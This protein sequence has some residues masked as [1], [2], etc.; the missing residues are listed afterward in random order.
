MPM[1]LRLPLLSL[2]LVLSLPA[3]AQPLLPPPGYRQPV[4]VS[5]SKSFRCPTP[6][7]PY[8]KPLDFPSKYEGSGKA[9]DQVNAQA[10][11]KY[12]SLTAP[13]T[14]MEKGV[15]KLVNRYLA[16]G[17]PAVLAC[18]LDWYQRW[19]D[20][21]ALRGTAVNHTGRSV[22]K[23]ALASLSGAWLRLRHAGNA[24]L[25]DETARAQRIERWLGAIGDQVLREWPANA[26]RERIN[27]HYYWAGWALMATSVATQRPDL[28][29]ASLQ[30][31]RVFATQ[32]DEDGYLP[33]ELARETRAL[34]YHNYSLGPLAMMAAFA[35]A[36]QVDLASEG[37]G[38]LQRLAQRTFM[39]LE[40]PSI[41]ERR[42]GFPQE[43]SDFDEPQ[44]K[45]AW[46]E[47]YCWT[48]ECGSEL[49]KR[50]D[51]LR[52]LGSYRLGGNLTPA[53][54]ER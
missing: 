9:R 49:R 42:T 15:S 34:S 29:D 3:T 21:N 30:L 41:F 4:P 6:P 51:A 47:P 52:P 39:G 35:R 2:L 53:F 19:S 27:N 26:A 10:E 37:Q 43:L 22:R 16:S 14:E 44:T 11:A 46:L 54:A 50:R 40:D 13:I 1:S 45:L 33:N 25:A 38:A 18:T 20:A 17:N 31:Y 23:W 36:N 48:L 8:T 24:P 7:T 28:F 12:R 5:E 32:V